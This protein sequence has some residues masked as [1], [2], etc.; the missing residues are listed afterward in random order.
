MTTTI[1]TKPPPILSNF[2]PYLLDPLF[3]LKMMVEKK[4]I[5]L[6]HLKIRDQDLGKKKEFYKLL[7]MF[8]EEYE[9][10]KVEEEEYKTKIKNAKKRSPLPAT[11]GTIRFTRFQSKE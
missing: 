5:P 11:R 10:K 4:I 8:Q 3:G 6:F 7:E 2:D 1:I 9:R